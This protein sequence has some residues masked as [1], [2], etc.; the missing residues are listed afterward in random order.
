MTIT[1]ISHPGQA[2][3]NVHNCLSVICIPLSQH[4]STFT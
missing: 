3:L 4:A 1:G 2:L